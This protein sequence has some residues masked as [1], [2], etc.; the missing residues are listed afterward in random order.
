MNANEAADAVLKRFVDRITNQAH[1]VIA[2]IVLLSKR[3]HWNVDEDILQS[4]CLRRINRQHYQKLD[5][6]GC[7]IR[8]AK[9]LSG[10]FRKACAYIESNRER[11]IKRRKAHEIAVDFDKFEEL[12]ICA[13][14]TI[15]MVEKRLD[16]RRALAKIPA[17]DASGA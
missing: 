16:L 10:G 5:I 13:I 4:A 2:E 15:A 3:E 7:A 17:E 8:R 9:K 6:S 11:S 14:D 12:D 1:E